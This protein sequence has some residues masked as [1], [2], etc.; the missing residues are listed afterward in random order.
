MLKRASVEYR[1]SVQGVGFRY[2]ATE[3]A[4]GFQVTGHVKN[5]TDGGVEIVAEGD[6]AEVAAFLKAIDARM[7]GLISSQDA[8]WSDATGEFDGFRIRV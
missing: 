6:R 4:A 7:G 8:R 1:G 3:T 2:S 5:L